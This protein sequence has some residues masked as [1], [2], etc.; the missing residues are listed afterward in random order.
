LKAKRPAFTSLGTIESDSE[1][2]YRYRIN[3]SILL[4][5]ARC[6]THPSISSKFEKN[7]AVSRLGFICAELDNHP[8]RT[9]SLTGASFSVQ[10][11]GEEYV[12]I[13]LRASL[14]KP[15]GIALKASDNPAVASWGLTCLSDYDKWKAAGGAVTRQG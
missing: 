15:L 7:R 8:K 12:T 4:D 14:L 11:I 5:T 9:E 13:V 6:C 2:Q 1:T 3:R 10:S